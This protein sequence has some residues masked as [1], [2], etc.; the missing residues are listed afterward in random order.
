MKKTR[1][2]LEWIPVA[3]AV[4]AAF[5]ILR[6]EMPKEKVEFESLTL[7][8]SFALLAG[9]FFM[10][11]FILKIAAACFYSQITFRDGVESSFKPILAKYI[12]GKVWVVLG[13]AHILSNKTGRSLVFWS[14]ALLYFQLIYIV[15]GLLTG[16]VGLLFF[17]IRPK[18]QI[19]VIPATIAL[20]IA[21]VVVIA[22]IN[23]IP[24]KLIP[25]KLAGL[26]TLRHSSL[27]P[28]FLLSTLQWLGLSLAY[29]IFMQSMGYSPN[30]LAVILLQPLANNLGLLAVF[31][32]GGIGV[33]ELV[34]SAYLNLA[35]I[36]VL[37][38][39]IIAIF[40]RIWFFAAEILVFGIGWV[41]SRKNNPSATR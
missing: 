33:R 11:A 40:A 41:L 38:A 27:L 6:F 31:A 17:P 24:A 13:P 12:P 3:A 23:A 26:R 28:V 37:Q 32:P 4:F 18:L 14:A 35:S 10:R 1:F 19:F 30:K 22:G 9:V 34:M 39:A 15:S 8:I 2:W 16:M 29:L 21:A 20:A 36:P 7:T 25:K 5:Y